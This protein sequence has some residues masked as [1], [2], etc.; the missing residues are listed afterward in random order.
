MD[1]AER[2]R[3]KDIKHWRMMRPRPELTSSARKDVASIAIELGEDPARVEEL[4]RD[5]DHGGAVGRNSLDEARIAL[6]M[7]RKGRL[8]EVVRDPRPGC[9]DLIEQDGAGQE[10]DVVSFRGNHFKNANV[11]RTLQEK[12]EDQRMDDR[13]LKVI[14]NTEYLSADQVAKIKEIVA[15]HG[16]SSVVIY[17]TSS[18]QT[19]GFSHE[20]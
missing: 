19:G 2:T 7:E 11:L 3:L 16:W 20:G 5:P 10:W 12:L 15:G 1:P 18:Q 8:R 6:T 4:V 9:G 14:V 13:R 17:G